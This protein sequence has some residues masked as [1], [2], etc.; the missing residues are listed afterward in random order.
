VR[1][2][3]AARKALAA[4]A[5]LLL[6]TH[7]GS[8]RSA[9][10]AADD[11]PRIGPCPVF[12]ATNAWN[13]DISHA[14]VDPHSAQYLASMQAA[15]HRITLDFPSPVGG[16][17]YDVM[18][19]RPSDFHTV[20]YTV[21]GAESDRVP[22]PI[23]AHPHIQANGDH[24]LI[25]VDTAACMLYELWLTK[26]DAAGVHAGCGARFDLRS[27][28]ER[29]DGW[30]SADAAGLA[31]FPGL[32]KYD[33][34]ATGTIRHALRFTVGATAAA[35]RPPARHQAP[36]NPVAW[37]PPMGL[38]LRLKASYDISALTGRNRTIARALQTYG[39]ILAD[40][41]G[42]FAISGAPDPRWDSASLDPLREI[43]ASA[44]EVIAAQ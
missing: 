36:R 22:F 6:A 10:G 17:P 26:I 18:A 28:A 33:E 7:G 1:R 12:P 30:T 27:N 44:F 42:E 39:M 13:T 24:H 32:V 8:P 25:V 20:D 37:S 9:A 14:P 40:N 5:A 41:G 21:Y 34:T 23:P 31:I 15:S 16:V 2:N 11:G 3:V 4:V 35:H 43:P 38:R 29:P 19:A